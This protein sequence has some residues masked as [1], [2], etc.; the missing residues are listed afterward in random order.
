MRCLFAHG[1]EG[2][3]NGRK[4]TWLAKHGYD[5]HAPPMAQYGWRFEDQVRVI[6]EGIDADPELTML[7]GSSMGGFAMAVAASRRP[8]RD[9]KLV[10]MAP[11]VGIHE[12]WA[13]QLG[14]DGINL[15]AEMG[16]LQYHHQGVGKQI[17]LP[18]ALFT[19]CRDSADVVLTHP[20]VII[21]GLH[22]EVIPVENAL[23]LAKRSPGVHRLHAVSDGHRLLNSLDF[24]R[25]AIKYLSQ[26]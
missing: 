2:V 21:H 18:Y 19:E 9:L 3:P 8:D 10:L 13:R 5:V 23:A 16:T 15:W 7:V 17:E 25:G 4:P 26:D 12:M 6:T 22:D 11:A 14:T 20:A 24:M 1:F